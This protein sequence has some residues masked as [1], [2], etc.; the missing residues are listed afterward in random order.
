MFRISVFSFK[1]SLRGVRHVV[2]TL[3]GASAG[4]IDHADKV[5][6]RIPN[7]V[8]QAGFPEP[9]VNMPE[10]LAGKNIILVGLPG[11]F[12]PT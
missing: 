1:S 6:T 7:T 12:T 8:L 3:S 2:R 5:G 10:H 11:A 4:T 9:F